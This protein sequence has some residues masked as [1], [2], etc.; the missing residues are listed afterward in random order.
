MEDTNEREY[1]EATVISKLYHGEVCEQRNC[2]EKSLFHRVYKRAYMI[3]Q[4][5]IELQLQKD[6]ELGIQE[7]NDNIIIFMGRRGTGKSSAMRSFMQSLLDNCNEE[8]EDSE[9]I[10]RLNGSNK[11]VRFLG[12]DSIDASLL[13][14][15]EDIFEAILAKMFNEFLKDNENTNSE[16]LTYEK[17]ELYQMFSS[18]Y[19][20][21]L[22]LKKRSFDDIYSSEA[23]I[24]DLRDLAR[25][26]DIKQEF[27]KLI[28]K[29]IQVKSYCEYGH[30]ERD[31]YET[32]LVVSID[33][34]D[35]NVE[36]GFE[37]LE[38]IQRYLKVKRLIVLL[39]VNHEQMKLCCQKH[40]QSIILNSRETFIEDLNRYVDDIADQYMG[41]ALPPY[42]RVYLPS[43]KKMDYDKNHTVKIRDNKNIENVYSVKQDIFLEAWR[44]TRVRYDTEGKKRH[45]LEPES[46]RDLNNWKI[47]RTYMK[48]LGNENSE[49]F[50]KTLDFNHRRAM[51]DLLF[52]YADEVLQNNESKFFILLSE[53]HIARRGRCILNE[54]FHQYY[55]QCKNPSNQMKYFRADY[56]RFGYSYGE[57]LRALYWIGRT[58]V[59]DK[60][61]VHAIL[62][63]YSLTLTKIFYR[64]KCECQYEEDL[65][66]QNNNRNYKII[67]EI[68]NGSVGGSWSK[69]L[70]PFLEKIKEISEG[71][72]RKE[73]KEWYFSGCMRQVLKK[74]S[75]ENVGFEVS[76]NVGKIL[77]DLSIEKKKI[78]IATCKNILT[79]LL[80]NMEWEFI[81]ILFLS[82]GDWF[83]DKKEKLEEKSNNEEN[84]NSNNGESS[85]NSIEGSDNENEHMIAEGFRSKIEGNQKEEYLYLIGKSDYNIMN[86]INNIFE[87]DERLRYFIRQLLGMI[88]KE[89]DCSSIKDEE[90]V[91]NETIKK[92]LSKQTNF[93]KDMYEWKKMY[94]GMI[95]PIYAIDVYYNMFKRHA[96]DRRL[97]HGNTIEK[98]E[99]FDSFSILLDDIKDALRKN[100]NVYDKLESLDQQGRFENI[101]ESCPFIKRV[102][103]ATEEEKEMYNNYIESMIFTEENKVNSLEDQ[104]LDLM[105]A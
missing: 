83:F 95:V 12:I 35:M 62:E 55:E 66:K 102:K 6:E 8:N 97:I 27:E 87:F 31:R 58:Y 37:I 98:N 41:K 19:R 23:A 18:I 40:F 33:D 38:K 50:L 69:S 1:S 45:F 26:V 14:A 96:R 54:F 65:E 81:L 104:M 16:A 71:T 73:K 34:I 64:Y 2:F 99:L 39:A 7:T 72:E 101:F 84:D 89:C 79:D 80:E 92:V 91:I 43:F 15:K 36:S 24:S 77:N 25:S 67:K 32:F 93:Y 88:R 61:L 103:S 53:L 63:M 47:Y 22:N 76:D 68:I 57:L 105:M 10:V 70:I 29:Y 46:L 60:K 20:K 28:E 100:D 49:D 74:D 52:R 85:N 90:K 17:R 21:H 86:F 3:I 4:K 82:N 30:N 51:D 42:S 75:Q 94:G 5:Q 78:T 11:K 59:Y 56:S 48:E 13:E 44:K 9:Y